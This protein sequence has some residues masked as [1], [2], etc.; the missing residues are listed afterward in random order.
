MFYKPKTS[1]TLYLKIGREF[2]KQG[3]PNPICVNRNLIKS[4]NMKNVWILLKSD[5]KYNKNNGKWICLR[6]VKRVGGPEFVE[7]FTRKNSFSYKIVPQIKKGGYELN[8]TS[9]RMLSFGC[10]NF[11]FSQ[12]E[13]IY[14]SLKYFEN[15]RINNPSIK[16]KGRFNFSLSLEEISRIYKFMKLIQ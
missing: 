1:D 6:D 14:K 5:L 8:I 15:Q 7:F 11:K 3:N 4:I 13:N 12:L 2:Y 16:T 10:K 9:K